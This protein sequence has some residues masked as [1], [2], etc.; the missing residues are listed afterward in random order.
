MFSNE[1]TSKNYCN[2][3]FVRQIYPALMG[4]EP[5]DEGFAYWVGEL[6]K[7]MK[8]ETLLNSFTSSNEYKKLCAEAGIE[9]GV[10]L[11]VPQ[12]GRQQYGPCAVCGS[13]SK[14]VQF[15]ERM[16]TECMKRPADD[17]GLAFWS[18]GL[19]EHTFTGKTVLYNFFLSSEIKNMGLANQ[20]YVRRIYKTMLDRD[21]DDDGL[22]YWTRRLDTGDSPKAVINGFIDSSEFTKICNDYGI[23]RK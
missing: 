11:N 7:G 4:R 17:G 21:P 12:Y 19:Y 6:G 23:V 16:Y 5:D 22:N 2:E 18:K 15:V 13:K 10:K 20:E 3:H 9:L 8:R 1:F 14:V